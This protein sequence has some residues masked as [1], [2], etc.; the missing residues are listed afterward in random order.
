MITWTAEKRID[1]SNGQPNKSMDLRAKQRLCY[2][3]RPLIFTLSLA[4]S[5]HVISTVRHLFCYP[6][7]MTRQI[8][9]NLII[10]QWLLGIISCVVYFAT[11]DYLPQ[12]LQSYLEELKNTEPTTNEWFLFT[13][14]FFLL[15]AY[16]VIYI[17]LYRFKG[18]AKRLLIPIHVFV[19]IIA[20]FSGVSIETGW[21]SAINYLYCLVDGGILF[22]VYLPPV[23]Q[24]FEA[25]GDV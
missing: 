9:K 14:G 21:V 11:I 13:I 19:L 15:I 25:N 1:F 23:S 2:Q 16:I 6:D 17:G 12:Q 5:P 10:L 7:V 3:R 20:L 18:W 24:M 4:V 22:L 8:F